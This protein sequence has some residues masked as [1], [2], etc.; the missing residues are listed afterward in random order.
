M[1]RRRLHA[2]LG[3]LSYSARA[4]KIMCR[5]FLVRPA[6]LSAFPKF[7]PRLGQSPLVSAGTEC[8]R[9]IECLVAGPGKQGKLFIGSLENAER[10]VR[11]AI[12]DLDVLHC[13][14][15]NKAELPGVIYISGLVRQ[16]T[17]N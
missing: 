6:S 14:V 17:R 2:F 13:V 5:E 10:A 4:H 8:A 11:R 9:H 15:P 3:T 7:S 12:Y 1:D 16:R